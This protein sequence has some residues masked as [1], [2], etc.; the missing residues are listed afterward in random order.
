MPLVSD[1]FYRLKKRRQSKSI[2]SS[3]M[4]SLDYFLLAPAITRRLLDRKERS[5]CFLVACS[6]GHHII[7][8]IRTIFHIIIITAPFFIEHNNPMYFLG[9]FLHAIFLR[10]YLVLQARGG[11]E[12]AHI[13]FFLFRYTFGFVS[14]HS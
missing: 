7:S 3:S 5:L 2:V 14:K 11:I 1:R 9:H 8:Y 4:Y 10:L 13:F 6:V 12:V